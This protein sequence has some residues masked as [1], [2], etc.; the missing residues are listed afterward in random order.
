MKII[1]DPRDIEAKSFRIVDNYSRRLKLPVSE[2]EVVK[3]VLHATS[4]LNYIKDLVFHPRAIENALTAIRKGGSIIADAGMVKAGI[5]KRMATSF[6]VKVV[7]FI[8]NKDILKRAQRLNVTRSILAM[9]KSAKSMNGGI[10][11]IGNAP[12][13]LF[14]VCDM[15][16]SGKAHPLLI[17]GVPVGFVGA[18]EAKKELRSLNIPYITNLSRYGGSSVAAACVNALLKI[19]VKQRERDA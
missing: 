15:V 5:N 9:R 16:R 1:T 10:V 3:R 8:N 13:A 19:A 11:A 12:T 7:C 17:I 14:E 2:R 6:G 18:K 4:D